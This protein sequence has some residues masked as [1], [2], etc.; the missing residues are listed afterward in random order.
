M[1]I[2]LKIWL[3]DLGSLS[4]RI[5]STTKCIGYKRHTRHKYFHRGNHKG[6]KPANF[7]RIV[8]LSKEVI[9]SIYELSISHPLTVSFS[10]VPLRV[11]GVHKWGITPPYLYPF[12]SLTKY[13]TR[14]YMSSHMGPLLLERPY[15]HITWCYTGEY[16]PNLQ[17]RLYLNV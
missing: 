5:K 12:K 4:E 2:F 13:K 16:C 8:K 6:E 17:Q 3:D 1:L 11:W 7:L 10:H 14:S 15:L 9:R